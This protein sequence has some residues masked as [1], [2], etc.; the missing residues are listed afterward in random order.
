MYVFPNIFLESNS[1]YLWND[2]NTYLLASNRIKFVQFIQFWNSLPNPLE[3]CNGIKQLNSYS[4]HQISLLELNDLIQMIWVAVTWVKL[5]VNSLKSCITFIARGGHTVYIYEVDGLTVHRK[6]RPTMR[7]RLHQNYIKIHSGGQC[8]VSSMSKQIV[9]PM[10]NV[11][12][13]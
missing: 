3:S 7:W 6:I 1:H 8:K 4:E 12:D 9:N 2:W 10:V 13:F 11:T 5:N